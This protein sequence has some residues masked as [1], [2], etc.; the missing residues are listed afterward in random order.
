MDLTVNLNS[1]YILSKNEEYFLKYIKNLFSENF[2]I[3]KIII[4]SAIP[5]KDVHI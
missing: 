3:S 5:Q 2:Q 1:V 4:I